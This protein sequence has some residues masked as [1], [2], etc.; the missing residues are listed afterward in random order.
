MLSITTSFPEGWQRV[1][2]RSVC[3]PTRIWNPTREPRQE[4]C[5]VDV[6]A[7][8]REN[9][10]IQSPQRVQAAQTPSRARKIIRT[11]DAIFA[12]VRPT[13]RRIAFVE[14]QFDNQIASTAFCIV[15]ADRGQ[16]APRFLY[17]A[18]QTDTFNEAVAKHQAGASYPAVSDKHV[19]EQS[20]LL[21]PKPEQEK[22]AAILWKVQRAIEVEEKLVATARELKQSA[23]RQL[24]TH[25]LR[26]ES[27][28]DTEL[29]Q[30]PKSWN[31]VPLGS[32]GRIGNG[33]TPLKANPGYWTNGAIPWL[34]SAKVY[35]ITIT[36]ADQF[37]TPAAVA[38]CHLPRVKPGSVLIA[39]TGQGKTLGNAAVTAIE[40][41]VSQHIAY[42]AFD[43]DSANPHF[44][45][46]FLESRYAELRSVALGGGSTKGALTCGFLKTFLVPC[47]K[48]NEQDELASALMTIEAKISLHERK[49]TALSDLFQTLLHELMTAQIRVDKLDIDTSE[50]QAT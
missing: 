9:L 20:I 50:V 45:R 8:S 16:A 17:Y 27:H 6:S 48:R 46:L 22:I 44:V 15:R 32:F 38:E 43:D 4:F 21:P 42:L 5:Y 29:G 19:L 7:V 14:E 36:K 2:L 10:S 26:G 41:C 24:F 13:L 30:L 40:T 25:G 18:L 1:T 35:D 34:T 11:G 33:S 47:P 39:I 3:E 23:M 49:R 28:H 12:T 37:V 31:A